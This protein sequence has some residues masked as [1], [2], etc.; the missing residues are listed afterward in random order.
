MLTESGNHARNTID[1]A[2]YGVDILV[3]KPMAL[4]ESHCSEM[5]NEAYK[6]QVTLSVVKQNRFNV[7]IM[8]LHEALEKGRFGKLILGTVRIRWCRKQEY[9]DQRDRRYRSNEYAKDVSGVFWIAKNADEAITVYNE[10]LKCTTL[11]LSQALTL[12]LI[13]ISEPTR[14]LS[15]SYGG[16]WV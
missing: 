15:I 3:E 16:V 9:Y 13:H 7:P 8:K 10:V 11:N 6:N 5:I 14:L 12:S 4:K 2:Q 1:L